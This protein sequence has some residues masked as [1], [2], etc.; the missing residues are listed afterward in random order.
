MAHVGAIQEWMMNPAK[1]WPQYRVWVILM[2]EACIAKTGECI[3]TIADLKSLAA[4]EQWKDALIMI[5]TNP[6]LSESHAVFVSILRWKSHAKLGNTK[7]AEKSL[8]IAIVNSPDNAMLQRAKGD[9]H[10]TREDWKS[11]LQ[12]YGK[13]VNLR[14]DVPAYWISYAFAQEKSGDLIS[15]QESLKFAVMLDSSRQQ[16]WLKLAYIC[17][18]NKQLPDAIEAYD[19]ALELQ[20]DAQIRAMR[21]ETLRQIESGVM[22]ASAE[23]YDSIYSASEKYQTHGSDSVYK[24]AWEHIQTILN[25]RKATS[26]LDLGCGPGQ[27]AEYLA[28][29]GYEL[30]YVGIDF[31]SVAIEQ[32]RKRCP[33]YSFYEEVLP[34]KS[35]SQ[36]GD[37]DI[38]I[39]TE[40]LEHIENDLALLESY[41]RGKFL[42]LTVPNFDSFGHIRYFLESNEVLE[43]YAHFFEKPIIQKV[44]ISEQSIL[45]VMS[46]V[47]A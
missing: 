46:G 26:I 6:E 7:S 23:Y 34:L 24:S 8:D 16:W 43:R 15:A 1:G 4:D 39:C 11:A 44:S 9:F 30:E 18:Q 13:S 12:C 40:V 25:K 35:Y 27:F 37:S 28:E 3:T 47:I 42:I 21:D 36:F 29:T 32:A 22:V 19:K 20:E 31:S 2:T 38:L 41:P 5:E 10:K 17:R 33:Q 14:E 45:W